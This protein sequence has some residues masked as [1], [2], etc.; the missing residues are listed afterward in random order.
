M[1]EQRKNSGAAIPIHALRMRDLMRPLAVL[2]VVCEA[3][4]HQAE[5]D[6]LRC[7]KLPGRMPAFGSTPNC[8]AAKTAA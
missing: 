5:A 2:S 6:P 4:R 8:S 1:A 7:P 3:C